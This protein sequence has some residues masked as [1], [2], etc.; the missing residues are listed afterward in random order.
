[1]RFEDGSVEEMAWD[2]QEVWKKFTFEKPTPIVEA[3]LDPENKVWLD[4]NRLNNRRVTKAGNTFARKQQFKVI[5]WAQQL[6]YLM[7]S[8]F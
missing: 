6:F 8:L 4:T 2:G 7:G 1:M 3:Y 5:V